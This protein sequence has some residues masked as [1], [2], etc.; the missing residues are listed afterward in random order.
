M[1]HGFLAAAAIPMSRC[2]A[3]DCTFQ[4]AKI[5]DSGREMSNPSDRAHRGEVGR[6]P[7]G[8]SRD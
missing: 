4:L 6:G 3:A 2:T 5:G 7:Y 8:S 1:Y